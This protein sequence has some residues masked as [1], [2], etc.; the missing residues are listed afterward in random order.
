MAEQ[1]QEK[2]ASAHTPE[3]PVLE[4]GTYEI[5]KR[6]LDEHAR[7]LQSRLGKLN[8]QRKEVFGA[9]ESTLL[10]AERI[11]DTPEDT[12]DD[13]PVAVVGT[14][15]GNQHHM[16]SMCVRILLEALG[17]KV[18]YLGPDVPL[19]D[20]AVVQR[21]READLV[22][23]SLTPPATGG[24]VARAVDTLGRFYDRSRP[25][26]LAFGGALPPGVDEELLDGPFA[27][28]DIFS[29]CRGFREENPSLIS[30]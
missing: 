11:T 25:Y 23:I 18:H 8:A 19:E 24:D 26:A 5:I 2:D 4:G 21:G 22:C 10:R 6:R 3:P 27:D 29:S 15:E 17:W 16:G 14:L 30:P 7:E 1:I 28:C 20:F 13:A 12:W 9:I